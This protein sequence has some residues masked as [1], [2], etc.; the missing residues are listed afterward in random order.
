MRVIE[1]SFVNFFLKD[2][3]DK[4]LVPIHDRLFLKRMSDI[5]E[6]I[7]E[8]EA[9]PVNASNKA[10]YIFNKHISESRMKYND[11]TLLQAIEINSCLRSYLLNQDT[12]KLNKGI[13]GTNSK[14][15]TLSYVNTEDTLDLNVA[16]ETIS[17]YMNV[18]CFR[19]SLD[20][21][22]TSRNGL[23]GEQFTKFVNTDDVYITV[24]LDPRLIKLILSPLLP[25]QLLRL[26]EVIL[27]NIIES[28]Y[29]LGVKADIYRTTL[30]LEY[31]KVNS[32]LYINNYED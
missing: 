6:G 32:I 16:I 15:T 10:E 20:A 24:T 18:T 8:I 1:N 7:W 3:V 28:A 14:E 25:K 23:E 27:G 30:T 11:E 4:G 9:K 17:A 29:N 2:F 5:P 21:P 19:N 22:V 12:T 31:L 26:R 13:V